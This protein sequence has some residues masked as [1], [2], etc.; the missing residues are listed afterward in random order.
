MF[1]EGGTCS[2]SK[3]P[4]KDNDFNFAVVICCGL[5]RVGRIP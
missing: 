1:T 2:Y 4:R 5:K 3:I